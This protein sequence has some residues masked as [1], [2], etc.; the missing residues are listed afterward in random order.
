MLIVQKGYRAKKYPIDCGDYRAKGEEKNAVCY[1]FIG[2]VLT[3]KI[4]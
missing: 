2:Q 3:P 1:F 4:V